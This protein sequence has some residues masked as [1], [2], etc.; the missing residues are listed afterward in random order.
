VS[1]A[2][3]ARVHGAAAVTRARSGAYAR[4]SSHGVNKDGGAIAPAP[5][6]TPADRLLRER[7][8]RNRSHQTFDLLDEDLENSLEHPAEPGVNERLVVLANRLPVTCSKDSQGTWRL[9]VR[10][11]TWSGVGL[12]AGGRLLGLAA[13]S[14]NASGTR[15]AWV[16][17]QPGRR[18]HW[19]GAKCRG[20]L[21]PP[22]RLHAW[23]MPRRWQ[24]CGGCCS[25]TGPEL[26]HRPPAQ[27][28]SAASCYWWL[29]CA[30]TS[31]V[32]CFD[33]RL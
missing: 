25:P 24:P 15:H 17:R 29:P 16:E 27:H 26:R 20:S 18:T 9:Q 22:A 2:H 10:G 11:A 8:R 23:P 30:F 7:I 14:A 32:A 19:G 5:L 21:R 33:A 28:D 13:A 3:G 31:T 6:A 4:F 12:A 1:C